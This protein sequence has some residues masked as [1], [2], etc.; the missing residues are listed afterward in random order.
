[1]DRSDLRHRP[2]LS[3]LANDLGDLL[4]DLLVVGLIFEV[5][6]AASAR[7]VVAHGSDEK[8][9]R[10]GIGRRNSRDDVGWI[11]HIGG[12]GDQVWLPG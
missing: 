8:H 9:N 1:M 12:N 10:S 3:N 4:D 11:H 6:H 7:R 2:P 5:G